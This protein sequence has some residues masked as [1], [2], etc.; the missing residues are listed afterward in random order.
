VVVARFTL[1]LRMLQALDSLGHLGMTQVK[2]DTLVA[3][4][5]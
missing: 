1:H 5:E 4:A 3:M 2:A